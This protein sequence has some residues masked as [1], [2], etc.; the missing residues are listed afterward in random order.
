MQKNPLI[1][2]TIERGTGLPQ[3]YQLKHILRDMVAKL[4]AGSPVPSEAELCQEFDVSRTTVRKALSDLIQEGL[5]FTIQ[6]KG[7]FAGGAKKRSSW[8]AQTGG[9]YADMT[10]RGF[11][12]TMKQLDL[13]IIPA[14]ENIARELQ[15]N[16]GE[17]VIKLV[18]LRFV[19]GKPF[20]ICTNYLIAR[21]YPGIENQE[22]GTHSL[23]STLRMVYGVKFVSG[24]RLIE[25]GSC[26]AEE[27]R[28]LQ[29][30]GN[31]PLLIMRSTMYDEKG[32]AIEHGVVRQRSDL[33]QII[34]NVIPH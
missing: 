6:G 19:D 32:E 9:L 15:V 27:A 25:A 30:P 31:S 28:L 1:N 22:I 14:E 16:E 12:V 10:E 20:D 23:Y 11:T 26:T 13:T 33:S 18:R 3:Y 8:V 7:T 5:I 34:I 21:K 4:P 2:G 17:S 24:V 29:I